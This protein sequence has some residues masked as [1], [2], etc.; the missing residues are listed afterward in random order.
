MAASCAT[1]H[2]AELPAPSIA[3]CPIVALDPAALPAWERPAFKPDSELLRQAG[4][5]QPGSAIAE[6]L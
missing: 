4:R 5:A 3:L 6:V 2:S 1:R